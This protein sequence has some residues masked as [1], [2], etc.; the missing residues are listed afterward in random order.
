MCAC[1]CG[2]SDWCSALCKPVFHLSV[3]L[4]AHTALCILLLTYGP[5]SPHFT[6]QFPGDGELGCPCFLLLL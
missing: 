5:C 2:Y 4:Y 3:L 6:D 1:V